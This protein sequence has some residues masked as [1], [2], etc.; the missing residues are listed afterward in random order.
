MRCS[1]ALQ[2]IR[3]IEKRQ[4]VEKDGDA[5]KY[6]RLLFQRRGIPEP[7][8]R[9]A[10][11]LPRRLLRMS[12]RPNKQQSKTTHDKG[13]KPH[14]PHRP[15]KAHPRP[16]ILKH[17]GIQ[18][19]SKPAA[20][21]GEPHSP[22]PLLLKVHGQDGNGRDREAARPQA[23]ADAL[24]EQ[25]LPEGGADAGEHEAQGDEQRAGGEKGAAVACVVEG[26]DDGS[27]GHEAE[28]LDGAD[29]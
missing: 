23:K 8:N 7:A 28:D 6:K 12:P 22:G 29:P 9:K 15:P 3:R 10:I 27:D 16:Q 2:I 26:A 21:R 24:R 20:D 19:R 11:L 14:D 18:R 4:V 13:Q 5:V 17:D 25:D 1:I